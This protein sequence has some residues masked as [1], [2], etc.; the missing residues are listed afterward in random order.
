MKACPGHA[1]GESGLDTWQCSVYYKGAHRSN[2]FMPA[3]FL[4]DHPERE[5]I[6]NGTKR[7]DSVSARALFKEL[8]FLPKT[9]W[10]YAPCLCGR[11]CDVACYRHLKGELK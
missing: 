8:D 10:G 9:N 11:A 7:F 2:P 6:L 1:I 4:K 3:D 5:D